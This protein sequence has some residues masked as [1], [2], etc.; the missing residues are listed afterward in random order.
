MSGIFLLQDDGQLVE[1]KEQAY[2]TEDHLQD[3][4]AK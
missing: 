4:L 3:L 2:I 1:M